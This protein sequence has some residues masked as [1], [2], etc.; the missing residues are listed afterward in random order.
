MPSFD[1]FFGATVRAEIDWEDDTIRVALLTGSWTPDRSLNF[2]SQLTNE[3]AA[4]DG[5]VAGGVAL[6][7]KTV[8][9]ADG[10]HR[11]GLD[12]D[13]PSWSFAATKAFRYAVYYKDTGAGSTSRLIGYRDLGAVSVSGAYT[14]VHDS[15]GF[16]RFGDAA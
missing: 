9:A 8:L 11:V 7:G 3:L 15:A 12:A 5:Y 14:L 10:S 16:I 13:N 2:Y 4:G 6:T 1:G